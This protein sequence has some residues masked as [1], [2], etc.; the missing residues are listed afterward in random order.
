MRKRVIILFTLWISFSGLS[1]GQNFT[2][3]GNITDKTTGET[4]LGAYVII[5]GTTKGS[6]SDIDGKYEIKGIQENRITLVCSYISYETAEIELTFDGNEKSVDFKL[7]GAQV[8]LAEVEVVARSNKESEKALMLEQKSALSV[9]QAIGSQELSRKGISD[10]EGAV[11]KVSGISK[12]EGVKNVF[13]RGLG[14]RFNSTFLNGFPLPSEDPEYKNIALDFFSS[15]VIQTVYVSKVFNP[16]LDGDV[17]GAN[18][19]IISKE[20]K[21]DHDFSVEFSGGFNSQTLSRGFLNVDGVNNFGYAINTTAPSESSLSGYDFKNSLDPVQSDSRLNNG[22]AATFGKKFLKNR[23]SFFLTGTYGTENNYLSGIVRETNTAGMI[24]VDQRYDEYEINTSHLVLSSLGYAGKN[25]SVDYNGAYIHANRQVFGDYFGLN[26][27]RFQS[28]DSE[29]GLMRR[30][31]VNDNSLIVNQLINKW[32]LSDRWKLNAGASFN[33][34]M[35]NE[36]DRRINHLSYENNIYLPIRSTGNQQRYF[37]TLGENDINIKVDAVYKLNTED[38]NASEIR[39]GYHGRFV[40]RDFEAV[41]YDHNVVFPQEFTSDGLLLDSYFNK[42]N[43]ANN[44]F[45]LERNMD[46]YSV[47]KFINSGYGE[48]N[49]R[50]GANLVA[51][52]GVRF[53]QVFVKVDYNVDDGGAEGTTYIDKMYVLPSFNIKYD[54]NP[55]NAFRFG[56]SKSYTL[57]QDKEISPFRYIGKNFRSQGNPGLKPATNYNVDLKWDNYI[58]NGEIFSLTGF[59]K[60]IQDPVSRVE[61]ASAG[62]FLTYDNISDYALISGIEAEFKKNLLNVGNHTVSFGMNGS[63]IIS[64][65]LLDTLQTFTNTTSELEGS[66]PFIINS[67]LTYSLVKDEIVWTNTLLFNYFQNRVYS[68]GTNGFQD[69]IEKGIPSLDFVT[70]LKFNKKWGISLKA[71]NILNPVFTLSRK[72]SVQNS[73]PVVLDEFRK[74]LDISLGVTYKFL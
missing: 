31:Q 38:E 3:K 50:L 42:E 2:V 10:A 37:S 16:T 46:E 26:N 11:T 54:L 73:S 49:Y 67:D 59:F 5:K 64:R 70:S 72:P 61:K 40:N 44:A 12:Q 45:R 71:K 13:V 47:E 69:I 25:Y 52:G 66:A 65:I 21:T 19:N 60:Y 15:D 14:D 28:T 30:Q 74:G 7:E 18:I 35:G 48:I 58:S 53:S 1:F 24:F 62:G 8:K 57:P 43:L 32:N 36:P 33:V 51:M 20:L 41:E 34:V 68:V 29:I 4:L 63:Y 17:G 27:S 23:L 39:F 56:A 55:K 22:L 6:I 9:I